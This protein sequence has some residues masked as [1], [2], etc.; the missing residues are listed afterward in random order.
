M[1]VS[2]VGCR[3][4]F[5]RGAQA[6]G[7]PECQVYRRD[8]SFLMFGSAWS[9]ARTLFDLFSKNFGLHTLFHVGKIG[10]GGSIYLS[11]GWGILDERTSDN[12]TDAF[13]TPEAARIRLGLAATLFHTRRHAKTN[14]RGGLSSRRRRIGR[15]GLLLY[16]TLCRHSETGP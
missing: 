16:F 13:T 5:L 10:I 8:N 3:D 6:W 4:A 2:H 1:G 9:Q 12:A 11:T 14:H 15:L 7:L